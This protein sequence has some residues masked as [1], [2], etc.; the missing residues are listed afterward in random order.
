MPD[1]S[2]SFNRYS[3]CLNN[4]LKY[5]DP[6]GELFGIDDIAYIAIGVAIV[7]GVANVA[8]NWN[9]INGFWQGLAA[10]GV[11]ALAGGMVAYT[12][13][14]GAS[15][16]AVAGTAAAGGAAT[17]ATNSIIAQTG[18][19]FK[20]FEDV[21]WG[22]VGECSI[23]GGVAGAASGVAG[24]YASFASWTFNG[25]EIKS[26][27]IRSAISSTLASGAGHVA[28]GTTMG[29]LKGNSLG[30]SIVN[31]FDDIGKDILIG[32]SIGVASTVGVSYAKGINPWTGEMI[33][34][35]SNSIN[36]YE[37]GQLG[38]NRAIN[39]FT[40][41][42]GMVLQREVTI[43]VENIRT[44]VDFVG[45]DKYGE[46]QLFEVKN[47][48]Y[49]RMTTNQQI[50]IPKLQQGITFIPYGQNAIRAG[51]TIN[52]PYTREFHFNYIHYK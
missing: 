25:M 34:S 14:V 44:R 40:S 18:E 23:V 26:P 2:Q 39:E 6:S 24:Y 1:F 52:V 5:T 45:Y 36:P 28:G 21:D 10:F 51:L 12:G 49:A 7:G 31:S 22:R 42:G 27:V 16:Y 29:L 47:G 13:G 30:S 41:Q 9:S 50:V 17:S 3:Y 4:P 20:G 33:S 48:P 32:G 38:V 8:A 19:N 37:K 15:I 43:E 46:F 35:G 11:G